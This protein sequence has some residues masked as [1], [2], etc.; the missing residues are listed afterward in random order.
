MSKQRKAITR[1]KRL[2]VW[3][4][5]SFFGHCAMARQNMVTIMKSDTATDEAKDTA[6]KIY[7]QLNTLSTQ[8][9][10]RKPKGDPQ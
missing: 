2:E 10:T 4:H 6:A 5:N 8:L 1:L 9:R 7:S 3:R